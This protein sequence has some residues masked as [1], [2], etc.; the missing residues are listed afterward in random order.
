MK[1]LLV[2]DKFYN[3]IKTEDLKKMKWIFLIIL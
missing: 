2:S 3:L 1:Y